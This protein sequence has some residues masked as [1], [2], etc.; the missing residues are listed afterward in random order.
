MMRDHGAESLAA[1]VVLVVALVMA[2]TTVA[3]TTMVGGCGDNSSGNVNGSNSDDGDSGSNKVVAVTTIF[4][5]LPLKS[6]CSERLESR[7]AQL[8]KPRSKSAVRRML[9]IIL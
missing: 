9:F 8:L 4:T 5:W 1:V 6:V 7:H 2:A 3:A